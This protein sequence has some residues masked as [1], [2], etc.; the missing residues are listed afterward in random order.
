MALVG[1]GVAYW[2]KKTALDRC[3]HLETEHLFGSYV[4]LNPVN[5]VISPLV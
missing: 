2:K 4:A 1:I 3:R 5:T